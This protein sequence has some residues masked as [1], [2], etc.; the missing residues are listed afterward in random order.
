MNVEKS[1]IEVL[2][3]ACEGEFVVG[4]Q[5]L[6]DALPFV[7][8]HIPASSVVLEERALA[9]L[10]RR[11]DDGGKPAQATDRP[12]VV[13]QSRRRLLAVTRWADDGGA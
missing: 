12:R 10:A 4:E 13:L 6:R 1:E 3:E 9:E 11:F 5:T 7:G 8:E 2:C